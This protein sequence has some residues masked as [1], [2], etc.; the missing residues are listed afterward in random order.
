M[1]GY[2][3]TVTARI[4]PDRRSPSVVLPTRVVLLPTRLTRYGAATPPVRTE[5][6]RLP[7]SKSVESSSDSPNRSGATA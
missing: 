3:R 7:V 1:T 6:D 4:P 5:T 2:R